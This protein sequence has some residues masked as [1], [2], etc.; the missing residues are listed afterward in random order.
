MMLGGIYLLAIAVC[1]AI[2][3]FCGFLINRKKHKNLLKQQEM[4]QPEF[5]MASGGI[6]S[7]ETSMVRTVT[8]TSNITAS[9]VTEGIATED[10]TTESMATE[11]IVVESNLTD[12]FN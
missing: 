6:D 11:A 10:I 12:N 2:F 7:M 1:L 5:V 4:V 3:S 9:T 8:T